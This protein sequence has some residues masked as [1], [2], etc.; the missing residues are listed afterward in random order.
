MDGCFDRLRSPNWYND[1]VKMLAGFYRYEQVERPCYWT[2]ER[3]LA[4]TWQEWSRDD[5]IPRI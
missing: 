3:M 5:G 2:W 4:K 1:G